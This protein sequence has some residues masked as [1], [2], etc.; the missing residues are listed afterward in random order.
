MTLPRPSIDDITAAADHYG[1]HLSEAEAAEHVALT[2]GALG[3]YDTV[4]KLYA[5]IAPAAPERAWTRPEPADNPFNAWYVTS[6]I[7]TGAEGPLSG[8]RIA[9]KDNVAV[10]GIPMMN[11]SRS[12][13]GFVPSEDA[14]VVTRLLDAGATIAGKAVCEDLC[15]SGSSF[16]AAT[17]PLPNPWNPEFANSGS[18][19]GSAALLSGGVV[20]LAV[21]CDQGGSIRMPAAWGGIVGHKPTW[22]LVPY[23]GCFP[24]ERTIDHVGP[25]GNSVTDVAVMLQV[26]AG[27]DGLDP[28][29]PDGLVPQDFIAAATQDVAGLRVGVLREGFGIPGMSDPRVDDLV[30]ESVASL[31]AA[32]ATVSEVSIPIHGD[33]AFD[34][35]A[36]IATD[37]A[38]Y[39]MFDGNGYGLNSLGYTDPEAMEY[40]SAGRRAHADEIASNVRHIALSGHYGLTRFGGSYYAR[41]RRLVPG[42][43]AAYDA[44]LA[45]VDVLVMPTIPFLPGR[46]LDPATTSISD[47]VA[48]ALGTLFNTAP[49]DATG[50]PGI[51]VPAGLVDGLPV[52]MMV[53][54]RRF[55]DATV[56]RAAAGFERVSGPFPTAP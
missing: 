20:D 35:W 55:D 19:S 8:K 50:H 48:A 5:E 43:I 25:M 32:G 49:F 22:G 14:T 24:I 40:F 34:I 41:A 36:V 15:F 11:G 46:L 28:R 7:S 29:Q 4:A 38:A 2:S 37:G 54:G 18:S 12:L 21:G 45:E 23:S 3:A 52:G 39:Q 42:L 13:E 31:E 17:G 6:D 1:F 16:T 47:T 9:V 27:P 44:A 30:R 56:L 51:S 10:A 33:G 26:M 53:V